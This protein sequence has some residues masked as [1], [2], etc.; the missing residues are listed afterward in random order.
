M[1]KDKR[2]KEG[3]ERSPAFWERV[4]R[5]AKEKERSLKRAAERNQKGTSS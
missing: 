1:S 5:K 4:D 3:K 2:K